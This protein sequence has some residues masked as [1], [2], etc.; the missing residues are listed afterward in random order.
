MQP[1]ISSST[2][3]VRDKPLM[4]PLTQYGRLAEKHWREHRPKM[5]RE[6]ER[7]RIL[8]QMLLEAEEK[9]KDE[10]AT[11]RTRLMQQG[12]TAQQAQT[13]AWEMV[14]EKYLLLPPEA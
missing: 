13:Q 1:L 10:M 7:K 5:V 2:C 4:T 8:H 11:L 14:R 3:S 6:L 9:T 12:S